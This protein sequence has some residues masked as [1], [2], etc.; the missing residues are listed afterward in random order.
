MEIENITISRGEYNDLRNRSKLLDKIEIMI[1]EEQES[2]GDLLTI[3]ERLL[4]ILD[5]WG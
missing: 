5:M 2:D 3:G 4:D 1:L